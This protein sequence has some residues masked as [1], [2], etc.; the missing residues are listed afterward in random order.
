MTKLSEVKELRQ[1]FLGAYLLC[2]SRAYLDADMDETE[3]LDEDHQKF[4]NSVHEIGHLVGIG[5]QPKNAWDHFLKLARKYQLSNQSYF[6]PE[7][8][9]LFL[10][11]Y[12]RQLKAVAEEEVGGVEDEFHCVLGDVP[13]KGT[14]DRWGWVPGQ[15]T[16]KIESG[17]KTKTGD[18]SRRLRLTDHKTNRAPY[19][20]DE[21]ENSIQFHIYAGY[22]FQKFPDL[23]EIDIVYDLV[24]HGQFTH[25][26]KRSEMADFF[27]WLSVQWD[28]IRNDKKR[29]PIVNKYC[30]WCRHKMTCP[31]FIKLVK[32]ANKGGVPVTVVNP[33]NEDEWRALFQT[34]T[35]VKASIKAL[36]K[37]AEEIAELFRIHLADVGPVPS[38]DG[39]EIYLMVN[40][41]FK[42][43]ASQ[44]YNALKGL[45]KQHMFCEVVDVK[46]EPLDRMMGNWPEI[47]KVVQ[48]LL[49]T[50]YV[51]P[52]LK[53]RKAR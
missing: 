12:D 34:Y 38:G 13:V 31:A 25:T 52:S 47:A 2:P 29:L 18:K 11:W 19:T 48:P 44:V 17:K 14:I 10:E 21:V 43:D 35:S 8:K 42:F 20:R 24:R 37:K 51:N 15:I 4:G 50:Y 39:K 53:E 45:N 23:D 30:G 7:T 27:D 46:K 49:Q 22:L 16:L 9:R 1:S 36:E 3:A 41:R 33:T 32:D 5:N 40:P 6:D 26:I 28:I